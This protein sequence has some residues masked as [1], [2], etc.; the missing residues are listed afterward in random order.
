[1]SSSW[2]TA[3]SHIYQYDESLLQLQGNILLLGTE[4]PL[5]ALDRAALRRDGV[6]APMSEEIAIVDG[7]LYTMCESASNKYIFGKFT[8]AKWC[9]ATDVE[10]FFEGEP[11][12]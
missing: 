9:Y 11:E 7:K 1:M 5:Y 8:S 12:R 3:Q 10:T 6:I 2:G 4:L